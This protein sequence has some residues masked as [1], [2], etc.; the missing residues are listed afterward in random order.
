MKKALLILLI[1]IIMFFGFNRISNAEMNLND[2]NTFLKNCKLSLTGSGGVRLN[3]Q[4]LIN[5]EGCTS[6]LNGFIDDHNLE[7][8]GTPAQWHFCLPP[9]G[10]NQQYIRAFIR[11]MEQNPKKL[12]ENVQVLLFSSLSK[13][14]PCD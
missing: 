2:G 6:Y 7:T 13:A 10:T 4:D 1:P 8:S 9:H 3:E 14:F 12:H 5:S 11:Y